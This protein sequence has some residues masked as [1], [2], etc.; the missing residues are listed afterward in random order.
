MIHAVYVSCP[1]ASGNR[2][3]FIELSG[4]NAISKF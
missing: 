2:P 4:K 1:K 3:V